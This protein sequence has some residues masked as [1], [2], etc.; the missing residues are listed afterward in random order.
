MDWL[1]DFLKKFGAEKALHYL[2]DFGF[3][4]SITLHFN[5]GAVEKVEVKNFIRAKLEVK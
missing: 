4:G 2:K 5:N 3:S 1:D